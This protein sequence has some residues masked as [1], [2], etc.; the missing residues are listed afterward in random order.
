MKKFKNIQDELLFLSEKNANKICN[1]H[2]VVK[3]AE[4]S[5]THLHSRFEW[6]N[7][8]AGHNW[9][10]WQARQIISLELQVIER[11]DGGEQQR[12][13]TKMF[14]S[15]KNDRIPSNGG[16]RRLET[17]MSD[18]KL[19]EELLSEA[20]DE[21]IRIRSKYRQLNELAEVFAVIDKVREKEYQAV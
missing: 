12:I 7:G 9:R 14:V 6:D 3:F 20:L 10:L 21:L 19:R 13:E 18:V 8:V 2:E 4:N 1:P 16:Y 17:V 15:L 11:S 5:K